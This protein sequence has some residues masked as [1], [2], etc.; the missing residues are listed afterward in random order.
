[1]TGKSYIR[2]AWLPFNLPQDKED[3][4][5]RLTE[6]GP[7][8]ARI[9]VVLAESEPQEKTG[10]PSAVTDADIDAWVSAQAHRGTRWLSELGA[11]AVGDKEALQIIEGALDTSEHLP[12]GISQRW[13]HP[14]KIAED[15]K[16]KR[17]TLK[18][19]IHE[20]IHERWASMPQI[21]AMTR[22]GLID[23]TRDEV[24]DFFS[25]FEGPSE[26]K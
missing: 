10:R 23:L 14:K 26:P 15:G 3:A 17:Y 4:F 6:F 8:A 25:G 21:Q 24:I 9:G 18:K 5:I 7:E 19:R 1:M 22:E 16:K 12:E 13:V 11:I 20:R 2:H